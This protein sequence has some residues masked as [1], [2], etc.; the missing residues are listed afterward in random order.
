MDRPGK[1]LRTLVALIGITV[2][3]I[4]LDNLLVA[5]AESLD[6]VFCPSVALALVLFMPAASG[7]VDLAFLLVGTRAMQDCASSTIRINHC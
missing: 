7:R 1:L 6:R 5:E 4:A 2:F 3:S